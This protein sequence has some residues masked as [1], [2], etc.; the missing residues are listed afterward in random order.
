MDFQ[1]AHL[2]SVEDIIIISKLKKKNLFLCRFN[3]IVTMLVLDNY[4]DNEF[5]SRKICRGANKHPFLHKN[6]S[7][8]TEKD[9]KQEHQI[10]VFSHKSK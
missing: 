5:A 6:G 2:I 10:A 4:Y 7:K 3:P 1:E 8:V 9:R